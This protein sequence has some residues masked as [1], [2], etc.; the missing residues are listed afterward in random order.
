MF[1]AVAVTMDSIMKPVLGTP[2]GTGSCPPAGW[3]RNPD[4]ED[5]RELRVALVL[6]DEDEAARVHQTLDAATAETPRKAGSSMEKTN[7]NSWLA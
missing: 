5:I 4:A 1:S 7:G 2:T 6:V 3:R